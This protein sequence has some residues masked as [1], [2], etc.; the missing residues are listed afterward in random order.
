MVSDVIERIREAE[1]EA[2][3]G[4]RAAKSRAREIV[5]KA[6]EASERMLEDMKR[7][8]REEGEALLKAARAEAERE[9]EML[10]RESR[11]SI[12]AVRNAGEKG[13]K[14]GVKRVLGSIAAAAK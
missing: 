4:A 5:A 11:S 7:K 2:E 8:V 10:V 3:D 6:H 14:A 13:I 9:A 1:R 12:E